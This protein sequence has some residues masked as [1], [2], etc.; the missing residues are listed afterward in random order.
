MAGVKAYASRSKGEQLPTTRVEDVG[1]H[2]APEPE[3]QPNANPDMDAEKEAG[4]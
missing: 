2:A 4:L 1:D 3:S